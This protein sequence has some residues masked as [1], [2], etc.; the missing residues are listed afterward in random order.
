MPQAV[1]EPESSCPTGSRS[2]RPRTPSEPAWEP[3]NRTRQPFP[4]STDVAAHTY[5]FASQLASL[6]STG[7]GASALAVAAATLVALGLGLGAEPGVFAPFLVAVTAVATAHGIAPALVTLAGSAVAAYVWLL[8][9][10]LALSFDPS[11]LRRLA[12]FRL[13]VFAASGLAIAFLVE[14]QRQRH[15]QLERSQ[16]QL[17]SFFAS[18][19]V[20]L[21][22]VATDGTITWANDVMHRMLG[23]DEGE[24][25]GT[26]FGDLHTD[27]MLAAE[28]VGRLIS[29]VAVENVRASLR[30]KDG[31]ACEVFL[32]SNTMLGDAASEG[33][34]VIVAALPILPPP[35]AEEDKL[36]IVSL[37]DRRAK[38]A[39]G[40]RSAPARS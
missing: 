31:T 12:F 7:Y 2:V 18:P 14:R 21:Q 6:A 36:A 16:R 22:V 37:M 38:A 26:A 40:P 28:V 20:G 30:R 17:R 4:R 33:S 34:G 11:G 32:N 25:V 1:R 13:S 29:G 10:L 24:Y 9:P 8:S 5:A 39:C 19:D 3:A 35:V 15:E 23:Y 27:A